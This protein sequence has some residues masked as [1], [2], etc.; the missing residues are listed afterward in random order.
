M[1]Y[2]ILNNI[3]ILI[4]YWV[5]IQNISNM[6]NHCNDLNEIKFILFILFICHKH[7]HSKCNVS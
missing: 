6:T 7:V 3:E 4:R 5:S 2:K 1:Q